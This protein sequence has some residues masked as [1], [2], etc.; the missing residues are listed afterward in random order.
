MNF[1]PFLQAHLVIQIHASTAIFAFFLGLYLLIARKGD[2][3]HKLLGKIWIGL[4]V[5]SAVSALAISEI[6]TWG[7]FSPIH[8][9]VIF[10]LWGAYEAVRDARAGKIMAHKK[11]IMS[12]YA[13]ALIGAGL[14]TF[15]PGRVMSRTFFADMPWVG[16]GIMA[17]SGVTLAIWLYYLNFKSKHAHRI[18]D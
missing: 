14:F 16:F 4:M 1:Q 18:A 7:Y 17:A 8:L 10:T 15:L 13:G 2:S 5:L 6:K 9:L 12:L 11:G 3:R